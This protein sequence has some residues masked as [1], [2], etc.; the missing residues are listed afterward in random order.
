VTDIVVGL[1]LDNTLVTYDE[2]FH[3]LAIEHGLVDVAT[4]KHKR[5]IRD[6]VRQ[7]AGGEDRWRA[8]Q[9][10]AYGPRM[11]DAVLSDGV[12]T[13][14]IDCRRRHV[15]VH[16]VSH[17][18]ESAASDPL[19][20]NL[21]TAALAWMREH[22]FFDEE[23][24]GLRPS[25]VWFEG[26]RGDKVARITELGCTHFVDDLEEVFREASFPPGVVKILYAPRDDRRP[27]ADEDLGAVGV[28]TAGVRTAGSWAAV[29][30]EIFDC[31]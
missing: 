20:T 9:G 29:H 1:D 22:G 21:R 23:G 8:L 10:I 15:P 11:C 17:R 7:M 27:A 31:A 4:P 28:R 16:I 18:T 6:L 30:K 24:F 13:F 26:T 3:A 12:E 2:L 19:G 25:N 14:L 5:F